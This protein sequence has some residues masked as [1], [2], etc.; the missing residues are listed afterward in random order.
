MNTITWFKNYA[1]ELHDTIEGINRN[2]IVLDDS[3][4]TKYLSE[5]SEADNH[6]LVGVMPSF[7]ST[8]SNVDEHQYKGYTQLLILQ[9][10]SYSSESYDDYIGIFETAF[11]VA[12]LVVE[13]LKEDASEGKCNFLSLLNISSIQ[14]V[15]VWNKSACNGWN[16]IFS[17][18]KFK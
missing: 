1:Q 11:S 2:R 6:L 10:T 14:I 16:I 12:S 9:K 17:F 3:E 18:D 15:P 4:L 7:T 8:G 13:K 5:H